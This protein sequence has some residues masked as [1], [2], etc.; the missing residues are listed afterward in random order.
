MRLVE[1]YS[2]TVRLPRIV[3]VVFSAL[4]LSSL[5]LYALSPAPPA[6]SKPNAPDI[7]LDKTGPEKGIAGAFITYSLLITNNTGGLLSGI[8]ITDTWT[9]QFMTYDGN[10]TTTGNLAVSATA[11]VT[12]PVPYIRFDL[13]PLAPGAAGQIHM[14]LYVIPAYQPFWN[15][16]VTL[17]SNSALA[18]S[19]AP[20]LTGSSDNVGT[21]AAA[22]L[23]YVS[24]VPS[25]TLQ[26]PGRLFTITYVVENRSRADAVDATN[27]VLTKVVPG[28]VTFMTAT[29]S[30]LV[31]YDALANAT[32][33]SLGTIT[34]GTAMT[35]EATYRIWPT[36][37]VEFLPYQLPNL[38]AEHCI[39]KSDETARIN[40]CVDHGTPFLDDVFE[41]VITTVIPS[42][43]PLPEMPNSNLIAHT[44]NN[45]P[46]T[47]TVYAYNPFTFTVNSLRITDTLPRYFGSPTYTFQYIGL[48][49]NFNPPTL[50]T[51]YSDSVVVWDSPPI[52]PWGVYSFT[53]LAF[54]PPTFPLP[55]NARGL[56]LENVQ[57][58]SYTNLHLASNRG[59]RNEADW[60]RLVD[61]YEQTHTY[62][63]VSPTMQIV[64]LPVVYSLTIV[65][66]GPTI[67]TNVK[68][69]DVLPSYT[70]C[71][72]RW[73][74][75]INGP[76]PTNSPTNTVAWD[77]GTLNPNGGS[78]NVQFE[79]IADGNI[80][81]TCF[82]S[83]YGS[84]PDTYIVPFD[85]LA[86]VVLLS[87]FQ[88][89]KTAL[90]TVATLGGVITY[91]ITFFNV[92]SSPAVMSVF[93]DV[94]PIGFFYNNSPTFTDASGITLLPNH[95]NEY[96]TTFQVNL[97]GS[98]ICDALPN[99]IPQG[100]GALG[101][102]IISPPGYVGTWRN[103]D[104]LAGV[105]VYPH[106]EI[107][108]AP[109]WIGAT[110]GEVTTY[111]VIISNNTSLSFN[112]L[113]VTDT[114]P[115]GF[116]FGG[117]IAGPQPVYTT[118]PYVVWDG[119]NLAGGGINN[120]IVF[121][122]TA[123]PFP[124]NYA[125]G[126]KTTSGTDPYF[127]AP[128]RFS[129]INVRT[130]TLAISKLARPGA[131]TPLGRF[132]YEA[133]LI[134]AGPHTVT[135]RAFTDT[136]PS[137]GPGVAS[138]RFEEM[139]NLSDPYQPVSA[140]P[141]SWRDIT[142]PPF[143]QSVRLAF[144][145]RAAA[146]V[147]TYLNKIETP[148]PTAGVGA[149]TA[150]MPA[151]WQVAEAIGYN[152][153]P[154][155]VL[156][157]VGLDKV[158][159]PTAT[160][161]GGYVVYTI[162]LVNLRPNVQ[163]INNTL[164]TDTL[165]NGFLFD[166]MLSGPNPGGTITQPVWNLGTV[167]FGEP[168]KVVLSFR[169]RVSDTVATGTYYNRVV[170]TAQGVDASDVV[171]IPPTDDIA[172]V[173]VN[174]SIGPPAPD[175]VISKSDG[176]SGVVVG[177]FITYT[178]R[179]TNTGGDVAQGVRLTETLPN[180]M[181][182]VGPVTWTLSG[183]VY[184]YDAPNLGNGQAAVAIFIAQVT[185][186]PAGNLYTNT[187]NIAASN[188]T[189]LGNNQAID[190][191]QVQRLDVSV[192]KSNGLNFPYAGQMLT[193]TITFTN[194]GNDIVH[195]VTLT[196]T[197]STNVTVV[198]GNWTNMGGG[199]YL[200]TYGSLNAGQS[201]S[202]S[203]VAQ[204]NAN[205]LGGD[206]LTNGVS[207]GFAGADAD[208][209]NNAA[210]DV[211]YINPANLDFFLDDGVGIVEVNQALVY[212]LTARNIGSSAATGV[213]FVVTPPAELAISSPPGWTQVGSTYQQTV[214][215]VPPN[216]IASVTF[217]A[218]VQNGLAPNTNIA[219]PGS[220]SAG[221]ED[222]P[223]N[224]R[225]TDTDIVHTARVGPDIIIIG[226]R[227]PA[228]VVRGQPTTIQITVTNIGNQE[229]S[230]WFFID[231][232]IDH[233]PVNRLDLSNWNVQVGRVNPER[234]MRVNTMQPNET[235]VIAHSLTISTGGT[236][237]IYLQADTCDSA[238]MGAGNNC[239]DPSYA[240]VAEVNEA[241]NIYGPLSVNV[242]DV[243]FIYL[244]LV[245]R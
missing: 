41:K 27:T 106:A 179:Y 28:G 162:T 180:G 91:S 17:M 75:I 63:S 128:F 14:R 150:T 224:N 214:A 4:T 188:E 48:G 211:D 20:T 136:L 170:A 34:V 245:M 238:S 165:P 196:E 237:Q 37:S 49:P 69:T 82:N 217:P 138:F 44:Y 147:G 113:R 3:V 242:S 102:T 117:M 47:M 114:L 176:R 187:V 45:R 184:G 171:D 87:P 132:V 68:I 42:P 55:L 227:F 191:D 129:P 21:Y 197:P 119:L 12:V 77:V 206:I 93:E 57:D 212:T 94:L 235:R 144:K 78:W 100:P 66:E 156:A 219:L 40:Y 81:W 33:W 203:L 209:S 99:S 72:F 58:G 36:A 208:T 148:T 194:I 86:P 111:T 122:A 130:A 186:V 142:V 5:L 204:V 115:P 52:G 231:T 169:V 198:D 108:L 67:L 121:T 153:S 107:K 26:R 158:V 79:A 9:N 185:S 51:V 22:P 54:V 226:A 199:S 50:V 137:L 10:F 112:N 118:S 109:N 166:S 30:S 178:I 29:P 83:T 189:N 151:G 1:N 35:V 2:P 213:T 244:P 141:P 18:A 64:G 182:F 127:C 173:Y 104:F 155:I 243:N 195:N 202:L 97:R 84:T 240:R 207:I 174:S 46:V 43:P 177:E 135:V 131:T 157:G 193:Y 60:T 190:V 133:F 241:N 205:V 225:F 8:S 159:A 24:H 123:S 103:P 92:S 172:P 11:F 201:A 152:G 233:Q 160:V 210:T 6:S 15:S 98:S 126:I 163:A 218:Q 70:G 181:S 32:V 167:S 145:T 221:N 139:E 164:V 149:F 215:D 234:A 134:N 73:S 192:S 13:A 19:P 53:F 232:Y 23:F 161:N 223:G 25:P 168:Y 39:I 74:R 105:Y 216:G 239:T 200:R 120:A 59:I 16:G 90:P 101:A 110:P 65:N 124:G 88:Y 80:G 228:A 175:L 31:R 71:S 183:G 236:H 95:Q 38:T 222:T 76:A 62:K 140:N 89:S 61:L 146:L 85:N 143:D 220:V 154:I 125:H 230:T 56:R 96:A 229:T 116:V 7:Q